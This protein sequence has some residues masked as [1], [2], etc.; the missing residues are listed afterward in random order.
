MPITRSRRRSLLFPR[1]FSAG[2]AARCAPA[3]DLLPLGQAANLVVKQ[4]DQDD[5]R[6]RDSEQPEKDR[7]IFFLSVGGELRSARHRA[8][9]T[10]APGPVAQAAALGGRECC[11]KG[12]DEQRQR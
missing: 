11:A 5:K 7:H 10:L 12:A 3:D 2:H 1:Q 9:W 6:D 8:E 4:H